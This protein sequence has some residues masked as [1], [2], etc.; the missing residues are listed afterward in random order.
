MF[1]ER[2]MGDTMN[3]SYGNGTGKPGHGRAAA[4][5][6]LGL[7][8]LAVCGIGLYMG[9]APILSPYPEDWIGWAR[10]TLAWSGV[11]AVGVVLLLLSLIGM[12][13]SLL[14]AKRRERTGMFVHYND[15]D[16]PPVFPERDTPAFGADTP[17]PANPAFENRDLETQALETQAFETQAAIAVPAALPMSI[18]ASEV[19]AQDATVFHDNASDS[20]MSQ[21]FDGGDALSETHGFKLAVPS[22]E[23]IPLRPA[24]PP[25]A[26][27]GEAPEDI[28]DPLPETIHA[29]TDD[30]PETMASEAAV[31]EAAASDAAEPPVAQP[32][33]PESGPEPMWQWREAAQD[34]L[35]TTTPEAASIAT[36][37]PE[38]AAIDPDAEVRQAVQTALSVWPDT[39]RV[40]A[41]EELTGR[42]THLYHDPAPDSER[43]FRLIA[44][45]DLNAAA[46][47]LQRHAEALT[48]A[49]Q[50]S[51]AAEVWRVIGALH[52]GRN[53]ARA[54]NAYEQVSALD[55]SDGNIHLYLARRYQMAGDTV[56]QPAVI[57]RALYVI[58]DPDTRAELLAPYADLLLKAGNVRSG[59]E[60][61]DELARLQ[62]NATRLRPDDMATRSAYAVTMARL[63][64]VRE[65]QG[66]PNA[67]GPLY[68]QAYRIFDDLS[69]RKPDHPGLRAMADKAR[70]DA[71]R[72]S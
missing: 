58:S 9:R 36:P 45:G 17:Q 2:K 11:F 6:A 24:A 13:R 56:R 20:F 49:G 3:A 35:Q 30:I 44:G 26:A 38:P 46:N 34:T 29:V 8:A 28:Q 43:A 53:D 68:K 59:G 40:I 65:M 51:R 42:L 10:T 64:Q 54:M 50:T 47:V 27:A 4:F 7:L 57:A 16:N 15:L 60:A 32:E 12:V 19:T 5:A 41:A 72:F 14:P 31:S 48:E 69:A 1:S 70:L 22:A 18:A 25:V 71:E 55:A 66:M 62:E 37:E 52:M 63:G 33:L 23:I 67:A 61:L 39:M 21:R